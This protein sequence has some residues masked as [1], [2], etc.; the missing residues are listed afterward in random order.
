VRLQQG[1]TIGPSSHLDE[2]QICQEAYIEATAAVVAAQPSQAGNVLEPEGSIIE[3][4][5]RAGPAS[6]S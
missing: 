1:A 5:W 4:N 6:G 3:V 2:R